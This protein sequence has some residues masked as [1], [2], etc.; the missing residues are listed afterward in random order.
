MGFT[1]E[2]TVTH[3][4][5]VGI[6]DMAVTNSGNIILSTYALG[7]CVGV[8]GY[9]P[10]AGVAG[11]IHIMLPAVGNRVGQKHSPYMFADTGMPMLVSELSSFKALRARMT[12]A[13]IGGASV[14]APTGGKS[15]FKIGD[16]N[17]MAVRSFCRKEGLRIVYEDV[18]GFVNRT[19]HFSIGKGLLT[20]KK[21]NGTDEI[22]MR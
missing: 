10:H 19:V 2:L 1:P 14:N 22:E 21:P 8:L 18:G 16:D 4:V 6:S 11:L 13:L 9:D 12:F 7:S 3:R 20:V 15:F 5:V 17:I